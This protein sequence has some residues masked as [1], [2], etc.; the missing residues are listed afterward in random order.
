[1]DKINYILNI[2]EQLEGQNTATQEIIKELRKE[3]KLLSTSSI[4]EHVAIKRKNLII[5]D[6]LELVAKVKIKTDYGFNVPSHSFKSKE[7]IEQ[8]GV[9]EDTVGDVK[10][11]FPSRTDEYEQAHFDELTDYVQSILDVKYESRYRLASPKEASVSTLSRENINRGL[12]RQ[13]EAEEFY[14]N[15]YVGRIDFY[16]VENNQA[17]TLY[18]GEKSFSNDEQDLLVARWSHDKANIFYDDRIGQ[19]VEFDGL[20]KVKMDFTRKMDT[21]NGE[22]VLYDPLV[23]GEED[24]A[25]IMKLESNKGDLSEMSL[26]T[27]TIGRTQNKLIRSS[28]NEIIIVQGSAGSGK[29]IIALYRISYLLDKAKEKRKDAIKLSENTVAFLGPNHLFLQHIDSALKGLGNE[30]ILKDTLPS[31]LKKIMFQKINQAEIPKIE[32]VINSSD[33]NGKGSIRYKEFIEAA[34]LHSIQN[35]AP[36]ID[37]FSVEMD[38]K[39]YEVPGIDVAVAYELTQTQNYVDRKNSV[40]NQLEQ[41]LTNAIQQNSEFESSIFKSITQYLEQKIDD[42]DVDFNSLSMRNGE[43]VV[44][45]TTINVIKTAASLVKSQNRKENAN[46]L[47]ASA[48]TAEARKLVVEANKHLNKD[49]ESFFKRHQERILSNLHDS[50]HVWVAEVY[51]EKITEL[52]QYREDIYVKNRITQYI[53]SLDIQHIPSLTT[54]LSDENIQK[55]EVVAQDEFVGLREK[56]QNQYVTFVINQTKEHLFDQFKY[57]FEKQ[58]K[59]KIEGQFLQ[60]KSYGIKIRFAQYNQ[61]ALPTITR[62]SDDNQFNARVKNSRLSQR[63]HQFLQSKFYDSHITLYQDILKDKHQLMGQYL[64]DL[65]YSKVKS[66]KDTLQSDDICGL[67][68]VYLILQGTSFT[69]PLLYTVV[70]EAQDLN[71]YSIWAVRQISRTNGIMLFGDL[72]Q[73]INP[74]NQFDSWEHY[75][76]LLGEV[77]YYNL[78]AN[79]R[80]T[81]PIVEF[82]N[83]IIASYANGKYKLPIKMYRDGAPVKLVEITEKE[84]SDTIKGEVERVKEK[85]YQ[86]IAIICKDHSEVM[87]IQKLLDGKPKFLLLGDKIEPEM[88]YII[89]TVAKSKGLQFDMVIIPNRNRYTESVFDKKLLYVATSRALHSLSVINIIISK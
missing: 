70:D 72:G 54:I 31:Y 17:E 76:A 52:V 8:A 15:P 1:M 9:L 6:I 84:M 26:I 28:L 19:V 34:T 42:L 45:E 40:A 50:F 53:K 56:L 7:L 88:K 65:P 51:G 29:S 3:V 46:S 64:H 49:L 10:E 13:Q 12:S 62:P 83:S 24:Q 79:Y 16:D 37:S 69:R 66:N 87:A 39:R 55:I 75:A 80:S 43:R 18:I 86:T 77:T 36:F 81:K 57:V 58:I 32:E 27:M 21:T 85:A 68:H 78:E 63:V 23:S 5:E 41:T 30:T 14:K 59:S 11:K 2:I 47:Q 73:N 71:P 33:E 22:L 74:S 48:E 35:M 25:L 4:E 20:G 38:G 82:S 89:T 61:F 44:S 67:F 60:S